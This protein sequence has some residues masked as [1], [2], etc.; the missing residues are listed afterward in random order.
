[1]NTTNNHSF[2][3]ELL[4]YIS[5]L[6]IKLLNLTWKLKLRIILRMI[7]Y[8]SR[9]RHLPN[10]SSWGGCYFEYLNN[11]HIFIYYS[12]RVLKDFYHFIT[13]TR[14]PISNDI[15]HLSTLNSP[16]LLYELRNSIKYELSIFEWAK[17]NALPTD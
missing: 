14:F 13:N 16:Y 2:I 17:R 15:I 10:M 9:A 4:E 8:W 1:M 11:V 7:G 3:S 6:K 12:P 5:F